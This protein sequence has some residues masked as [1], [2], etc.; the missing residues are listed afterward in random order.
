M[1]AVGTVLG[2]GYPFAVYFLRGSMPAAS[3]VLLALCLLMLRL[4]TLR[5]A[6]ARLWTPPLLVTAAVLVVTTL[7]NAEIAEKAYPA[8]MS[9]TAAFAFAWSLRH[10]PSLI[11]RFAR[12]RQPELP[13]EGVAY[14]RKVTVIW[15]IWLS[16]NA[17]VA[18]VLALWGGLA[19]WALWTGFISY[20]VTG[21]LV[22]SEF[23]VRRLMP[24]YRSGR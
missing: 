3:F 18:T 14:C 5:S 9:L 24:A 16:L 8:L 1:F 19:L 20:L 10:P 22:V 2:V 4:V 15:A 6:T 17:V 23:A 11:E 12:L 21:L 7:L 13:L